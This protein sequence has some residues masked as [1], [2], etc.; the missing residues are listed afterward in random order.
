MSVRDWVL[1]DG[2]RCPRCSGPAETPTPDEDEDDEYE[3]ELRCLDC[4]HRWQD[5]RAGQ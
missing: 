2:Y 1:I 5:V 4:G 3:F